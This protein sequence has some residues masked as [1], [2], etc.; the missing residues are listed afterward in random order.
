MP[1]IPAS[2]VGLGQTIAYGAVPTTLLHI[3]D[4]AYSGSKVDTSDTTD[5]SATSG[6]RTFIPALRDAGDCTVKGIW[7]P[8]ETTQEGLEALKGA[9]ETWVHTLPNSL[10][11]LRYT[12]MLISLDKTSPMDKAGEFTLKLKIS[13]ALAWTSS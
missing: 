8:G 12:A 6:Y 5:T 3:T 2:F 9:S 11:V 10:G 1:T 13:G 7:Y 4:V